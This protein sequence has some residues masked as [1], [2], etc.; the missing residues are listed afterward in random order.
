MDK[1]NKPLDDHNDDQDDNTIDEDTLLAD[2]AERLGID[3]DT[4]DEDLKTI[5][6]N[7]V[8]R[9]KEHKKEL[10]I[11][12]RQK[13]THRTE[14]E[15]LQKELDQLKDT[16]NNQN[17]KQ[18]SDKEI[19]DMVDARMRAR[20]NEQQLA[21]LN[22]SEELAEEVAEYAVFKKQT[23]KEVIKTGVIKD[24]IDSYRQE[25]R[26]IDAT[27][28]RKKEQGVNGIRVDITKPLDHKDF[29][30]ADGNIDVEAWEA[31]KARRHKHVMSES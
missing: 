31:A 16:P 6:N 24:K 27:P 19:E 8:E 3:P 9:E 12:I 28:N 15:N 14:K 23:V 4:D 22:L 7:V 17:N 26:L 29:M 20:E 1:D 21:E 2:T 30:T 25:Q 18:L 10:D 13:Q 5:L 11:T